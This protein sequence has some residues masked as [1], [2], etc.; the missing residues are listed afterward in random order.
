[1]VDEGE[2]SVG[3]D[4]IVSF[5]EDADGELYVLDLAGAVRRLDAA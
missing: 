3:G 5:V 2:L 4:A 1:V